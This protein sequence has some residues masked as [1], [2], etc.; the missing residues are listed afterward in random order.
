LSLTILRVRSH[1]VLALRQKVLRPDSSLKEC[2][3]EWDDDP[4]SIHLGLYKFEELLSIASFLQMSHK[5]FSAGYPYRLRGMATLENSRANGYGS[6][7]LRE[8]QAQLVYLR[9]DLLWF[10]ARVRAIPFYEKLGFMTFGEAFD[11][12]GTGSHKTMYKRLIPR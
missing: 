3:F 11:I 7:L 5:N 9:S 2:R 8:G 6:M 4:A 10:N 12:T 1:E